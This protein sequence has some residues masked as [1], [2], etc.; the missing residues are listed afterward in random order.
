MIN[1]SKETKMYNLQI[2][3]G[4]QILK[5]K[6]YLPNE[7]AFILTYILEQLAH[8]LVDYRRAVERLSFNY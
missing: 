7:I 2:K 1:E 8:P 4:C 3:I 5:N 6:H